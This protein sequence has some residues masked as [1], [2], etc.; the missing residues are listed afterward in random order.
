[1]TSLQAFRIVATEFA[2]V[3][4]NTV[5]AAIEFVSN[6]ISESKYG[7]DYTKAIAYLAA[8]FLAWQSIVSTGST[9]GAATGGRI[10]SENEGDLARSYDDNSGNQSSGS[11][12]DNYERTAYGLEFLRL[13]RKH[14]LPVMTR[15]G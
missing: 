3:S 6:E 12:T 4:D 9:T 11:F 1:M 5:T 15:F 2:A 7:S 8:H 13:R 10:V 14:I